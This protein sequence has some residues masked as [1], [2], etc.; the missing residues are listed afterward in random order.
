MLLGLEHSV[1]VEYASKTF[2]SFC[3]CFRQKAVDLE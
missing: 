1:I 3:N 2:G